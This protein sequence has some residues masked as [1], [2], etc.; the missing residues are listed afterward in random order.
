MSVFL[1]NVQNPKARRKRLG[2]KKKPSVSQSEILKKWR[3]TRGHVSCSERLLV[4]QA[5]T[6]HVPN[7]FSG[8]CTIQQLRWLVVLCGDERHFCDDAVVG[9]SSDQDL[10]LGSSFV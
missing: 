8:S 4:C 2:R 7:I 6:S 3:L 9:L 1:D 5:G 10:N